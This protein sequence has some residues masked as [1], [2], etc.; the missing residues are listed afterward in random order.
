[1]NSGLYVNL[2]EVKLPESIQVLTKQ[3]DGESREKLT[4]QIYP[5]NLYGDTE[6]KKLFVYGEEENISDADIDGFQLL[7][8]NTQ[9]NPQFIG[10]Y[11]LDV[12]TFGL[13]RKGFDF[14]QRPYTTYK[15]ELVNKQSPLLIHQGSLGVY[16]AYNIQVM[17]LNF[18]GT[19]KY[20]LVVSPK[21][22]F[23]FILPVERYVAKVNC[24][25]RI[26]KVI[27]PTACMNYD[28]ELHKWKGRIVGKFNGFLNTGF[29]CK[30][31]DLEES[32]TSHFDL[33]DS[34][35]ELNI[36]TQVC[37]FEASLANIRYIFES[38]LGSEKASELITKLKVISGDLQSSRHVNLEV[39]RKRYEDCLRFVKQNSNYDLF[40]TKLEVF[41]QP[42]RA[43]EGVPL[44]KQ[45]Y[46]YSV[47]E[48]KD[49]DIGD[50]P[51]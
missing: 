35:L 18:E 26:M 25:G 34:R 3:W 45:G 1:M 6:N 21:L 2:F 20:C 43:I 15:R 33:S 39:G 22:R 46:S 23:D 42:I 48:G 17:Y 37:H 31:L 44:D 36:P 27:C 28:C 30:F 41:Q 9:E 5:L 14:E 8:L 29:T 32:T 40:G 10:R 38:V 50:I 13:L 51:F 47:E 49:D 7:P 4:S 16:Q 24:T 19:L 12:I 11:V